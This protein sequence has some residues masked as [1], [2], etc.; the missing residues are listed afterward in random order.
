MKSRRGWEMATLSESCF[1]FMRYSFGL[2]IDVN[3]E[4]AKKSAS[5]TS[6]SKLRCS[7]DAVVLSHTPPLAYEH[8]YRS[9]G[10]IRAT[11]L[12]IL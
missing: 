5:P 11:P 6:L 8:A 3:T 9:V 4:R 7:Q 10:K 2:S 12:L 1:S